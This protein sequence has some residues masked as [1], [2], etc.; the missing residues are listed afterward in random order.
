M[1]RLPNNLIIDVNEVSQSFDLNEITGVDLSQEPDL[2]N[3]IG[4][5]II[6][7]I[8]NR[9]KG[10]KDLRGNNFAEYAESYKKSD[11]FEAF[12]K[13]NNVNMTL[14]DDMS[15]AL[16]IVEDSG[17]EIKIGWGDTTNNAKAYNHMTGDT[18]KKRQFFGIQ[19]KQVSEIVKE[20]KGDID[21]LKKDQEPTDLVSRLSVT[22][23]ENENETII[24]EVGELFG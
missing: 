12:G 21:R 4:Q 5:A 1:A 2:K 16:D 13:G 3:R 22:T 10:G 9:Y 23:T 17:G 20:F 15:S 18:V 19:K 24:I 7:K 6:D 8:V 14:T 11:T